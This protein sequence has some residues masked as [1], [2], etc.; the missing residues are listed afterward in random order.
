VNICVSLGLMSCG[1]TLEGAKVGAGEGAG[2]S[3]PCGY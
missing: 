3:S 2:G 1:L